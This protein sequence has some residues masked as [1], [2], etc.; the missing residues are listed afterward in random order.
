MKGDWGESMLPVYR[1]SPL[2]NR[3]Q[4]QFVRYAYDGAQ[5]RTFRP[6]HTR[7]PVLS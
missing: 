3:A 4:R 5:V 2:P 6:P 1:Q 7:I